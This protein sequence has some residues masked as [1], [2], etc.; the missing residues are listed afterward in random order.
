MPANGPQLNSLR[1]RDFLTQQIWHFPQA[2]SY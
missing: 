1:F 2:H